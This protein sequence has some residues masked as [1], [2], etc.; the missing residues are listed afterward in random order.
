VRWCLR[1]YVR[2]R[3]REGNRVSVEICRGLARCASLDTAGMG[4]A[5]GKGMNHAER[6][7]ILASLELTTAAL[8]NVEETGVDPAHD[9][10]RVRNGMSGA[11]LLAECLDGAEAARIGGWQEYVISIEVAVARTA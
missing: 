6:R 4:S 1:A 9:Y 10:E 7:E 5:F 3:E 2:W 8:E 11:D